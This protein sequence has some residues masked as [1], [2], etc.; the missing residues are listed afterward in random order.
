MVFMPDWLMVK[1]SK[2]IDSKHGIMYLVKKHR[3]ENQSARLGRY[4]VE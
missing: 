4:Y 2:Y 3:E 1:N